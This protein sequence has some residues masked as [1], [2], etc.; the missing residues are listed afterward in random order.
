MNP[1]PCWQS[2]GK[3][4]IPIL[5]L[6]SL[7]VAVPVPAVA[8]SAAESCSYT[9]A[10]DVPTAMRDGTILRSN[11]F[12]PT[13]PGTFPVI[14]LRLPYNKDLAQTYVYA[15]PGFYASHCYIVV[16][17]DVRGQYK[18]NDGYDTI[19]MGG[20]AAEVERQGRHVRLLLSRRDAAPSRY[21][22][23]SAPGGDRARDD[24][25]RL[26]RRLD[27]R[28]RGPRPVIRRGLAVDDPG[29]QPCPPLPGR[30]SARR[31]DEPGR[32]RGIH[33]MVLVS[34]AQGFPAA[35]SRGP[36][37]RPLLLRLVA[38]PGQR[39]LLEAVEHPRAL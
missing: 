1:I 7:A 25:I 2:S 20:G 4:S 26:P 32:R 19:E 35:P 31:R 24:C 29:Q 36:S 34:S 3:R 39:R 9:K 22:A 12:T 37:R 33:E 30:R 27:L 5:L 8:A 15:S 28:G 14:L 17:Q 16:V 11:V 18:S 10:D 23:S 21:A 13:A 38:A 6:A